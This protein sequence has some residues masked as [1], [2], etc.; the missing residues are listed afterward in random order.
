V[1]NFVWV[2]S[3]IAEERSGFLSGQNRNPRIVREKRALRM[4]KCLADYYA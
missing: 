3:A 1:T 4:T 2:G